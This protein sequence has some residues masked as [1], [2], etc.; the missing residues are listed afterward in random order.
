M[1]SKRSR[2]D[3][4]LSSKLKIPRKEIKLILAKGLISIDGVI[5]NDAQHFVE[6]FSRVSYNGQVLQSKIP[7]YLMLHKLKGIVSATKDEVHSTVI[8]L[9]DVAYKNE[10]HIVGRLDFNSTGLLLLTNNGR[11]SRALMS[12]ES[13]VS[14]RYLVTLE[15]PITQDMLQA[16]AEGIYFSYENITTKP[17]VLKIISENIAEV[18]LSEGRYHQIKRMFGHFQNKVIEI[19][20]LSIGKILLDEGLM[21]GESRSL[22]ELEISL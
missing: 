2:L 17:A 3:R 10:L 21:P 22:T 6:E 12:P 15:R 7:H 9:L 5:I 11:W 1:Q 14:K 19:H 18:V 16:F 13:K 4:F 8:D 20:R